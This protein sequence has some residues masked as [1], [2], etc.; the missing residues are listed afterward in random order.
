MPTRRLMVFTMQT[1]NT[2]KIDKIYFAKLLF[3]C[4]VVVVI[5]D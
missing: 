5:T 1:K 3:T 4:I 2:A